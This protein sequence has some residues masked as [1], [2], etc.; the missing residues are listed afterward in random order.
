MKWIATEKFDDGTV[1]GVGKYES[2]PDVL[3]VANLEVWADF[4]GSSQEEQLHVYDNS[5]EWF[6]LDKGDVSALVAL[7]QAVKASGEVAS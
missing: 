5:P 2:D 4:E 6:F 3:V 7:L 1:I